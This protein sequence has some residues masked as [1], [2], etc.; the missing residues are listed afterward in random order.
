MSFLKHKT[1]AF[2]WINLAVL[3]VF[4]ICAAAYSQTDAAASQEEEAGFS[5]DQRIQYLAFVVEH[6]PAGQQERLPEAAATSLLGQQVP[7]FQ[8][9]LAAPAAASRIRVLAQLHWG[10]LQLVD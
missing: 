1:K 10:Q 6:Q 8:A 5:L 9:D 4:G 2:V 7:V 3:F